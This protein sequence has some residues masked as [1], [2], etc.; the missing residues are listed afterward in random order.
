MKC[1]KLNKFTHRD[2]HNTPV[3]VCVYS[4]GAVSISA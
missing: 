4:I 1:N 2:N 3:V